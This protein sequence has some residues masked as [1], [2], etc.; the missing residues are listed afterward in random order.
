MQSYKSLNNI[1]Q[2]IDNYDAF[3][4][5][6]WGVLWDGIKAYKYAKLTL[7]KLKEKNKNIILLSNAPR[8]AKIVSDKLNSIGINNSLYD[9]IVWSGEVCREECLSNKKRLS[10]LGENYYFI[11][12]ELDKGIATN[13]E[14]K[15]V[16][17]INKSSFVLVCGT[18][19]FDH[20]LNNYK[21]ELNEALKYNLPLVCANP[22]KVVI[23][24]NGQ[25]ITCAGILADYYHNNG[26]EVFRYG[27]PFQAMYEK[28]F[29]I[30]KSFNTKLALD[31]V[32]VIGDSLETDILGANN[33][34][35]NSLLITNGIHKYELINSNNYEVY[36]NSIDKLCKKYSA[37]PNYIIK[38]FIF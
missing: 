12:Q 31:K 4:I 14:I 11:G 21:K 27:K 25:L 20:T 35:L 30:L 8:R 23:R 6:I 15:E 17:S 19:D 33:N 28:S 10:L 22:D 34:K 24:Q 1:N 16:S 37:F 9:N 29:N 7:K 18:R 13:L 38:D 5:D 32:L 26:G 2:I 36:K 3:I